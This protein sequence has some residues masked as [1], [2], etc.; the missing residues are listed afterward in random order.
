MSIVL[1]SGMSSEDCTPRSLNLRAETATRPSNDPRRAVEVVDRRA[2]GTTHFH[3]MSGVCCQPVMKLL[4]DLLDFQGVLSDL[5]FLPAHLDGFEQRH[6]CIGSGDDDLLLH[7]AVEQ[8]WVAFQ[9]GAEAGTRLAGTLRR[10]Q[11]TCLARPSRTF[12]RDRK[13]GT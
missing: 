9:G 8:S 4:S 10:T 7:S 1:T 2:E 3:V 6:Q 12:G 5:R 13:R 11:G